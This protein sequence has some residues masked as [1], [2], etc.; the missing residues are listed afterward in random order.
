MADPGFLPRAPQRPPS[1]DYAYLRGVG[2][3][4]IERL[5]H[6]E[7]TD[8]NVHD[9]GVTLLEL[10]AFVWT[11]AGMRCAYAV[12][13]LLTRIRDG[14]PVSVGDFHLADEIL[15]CNPVSFDDLRKVLADVPGVRNAWIECHKS[16]VY[17]LDAKNERLSDAAR[18]PA[19]PPVNGLFDV[20]LEYEESVVDGPPVFRSIG[21]AG[22]PDVSGPG[23]FI[24]PEAKGIE[25]VVLSDCRLLS[26]AVY[27]EQASGITV[28]LTDVAG[29][30]LARSS[31]TPAVAGA[32]TRVALD[33]GL[34][35]GRTYRLDAKGTT[36]KLHRTTDAGYPLELPGVVRLVQ[37]HPAGAYYYFFYDWEIAHD[38]AGL[39]KGEVRAGV[40]ER[41]HAHRNLCE[42]V[43]NVCDLAPEEVAVCADIQLAPEADTE[44]AQAEILYR[45]GELVSPTVRFHSIEE[46]RARGR[47]IDEVFEGPLLEHGFI[48]DEEFDAI[49]RKCEIRASDAVQEIMNVPGVVAVRSIRLLSF[50]DDRL[51]AQADWQLALAE[52]RFRIAVFS[53]ARSK[54]V[55]YKHDLPYYADRRRV[56]ILLR[57]RKAADLASRLKGHMR[58]LPVPIGTAREPA[59][60]YPA[61]NELPA[62]YCVG[63]V[64]V[65]QSET[66][67]RKAQSRQLRGYLM[68]FEQ[69]LANFLAQLAHLAELF[70]WRDT[71]ASTYFTQEV[72]GLP[73]FV[74]LDHIEHRRA[75]GHATFLAALES[76]IERPEV[77]TDRRLRLLEHLA[78]RYCEGFA[79]YSALMGAMLGNSAGAR[80]VADK[81]RFL[82]DY[83]AA[84]AGRGT[85]F[86]WR[87]PEVAENLS[88]FQRRVYRLL[89]IADATRRPLAGHRFAIVTEGGTPPQWHFELR[90]EAPEGEAG[91][92][93]F[94]SVPCESRAAIEALLD[95]CL[96]LGA[97]PA[98]FTEAADG[99]RQ[100]I[101]VCAPDKP[102]EALGEVPKEV[103]LEE[104]TDYF[105]RYATA[106]GFHLIE[107]VL[108]RKRTAADPFLPVQIDAAADCACPEVRDPYSFRVAI[109]LPSWSTRFRDTRFRTLV[110][111]TLRR[112]APAHVHARICWVSHTEM[113]ELEV[114]LEEW[115]AKLAAR[116]AEPGACGA[117]DD[118]TRTGRMPLPAG[119]SDQDAEYAAALQRLIQRLYSL[120]SVYPLARLHDC[121]EADGTTPQVTLNNTSLGTL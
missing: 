12:R 77:A 49:R 54:L 30:E 115:Q 18:H 1:Q 32:A 48:D 43:V 52:D 112:E 56:E 20:F 26:V 97:D 13:D 47:T 84:S 14:T 86:D 117:S 113:C 106:E 53:P 50:V 38:S 103:A 40:I 65:A 66:A 7:W 16:V 76:I 5:A 46:L 93:L 114:A 27:A 119:T 94:E 92:L 24:A 21:H 105:A 2:L 89:G 34:I 82:E 51:R 83:P 71:A 104:V 120:T 15:P 98:N 31:A 101:Q 60:Y 36:V 45:L 22:R 91:P 111:D 23:G 88:G 39:T 55:F 33:F 8:L 29:N 75:A 6:E 107:L 118:A 102:P 9:P 99:S 10:M 59:E 80:L 73:D 17:R 108:L 78:A 85:G 58:T 70:T 96:G 100:L 62:T 42:D 68:F 74:D 69:S 81:R 90:G 121:R 95:H 44:A 67:A 11:D 109:V 64:R 116:A 19:N 87:R 37:G 110:E 63:R 3:R 25:F 57:E 79:E 35:A 4:A 72:A 28:R 61:Q 41:I